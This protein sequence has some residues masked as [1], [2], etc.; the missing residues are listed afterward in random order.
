MESPLVLHS[1]SQELRTCLRVKI[2]VQSCPESRLCLALLSVGVH[3]VVSAS[4][5]T[6]VLGAVL[7]VAVRA[8]S[9][10]DRVFWI[11]RYLDILRRSTTLNS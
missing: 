9:Q 10:S 11:P 2:Q 1:I 6:V 4:L 7:A 8:F 3:T 5:I